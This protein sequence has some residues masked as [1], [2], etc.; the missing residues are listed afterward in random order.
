MSRVLSSD[1]SLNPGLT[2]VILAG[3]WLA[4]VAACEMRRG[5]QRVFHQPLT[6]LERC[7]EPVCPE[8]VCP[9]AAPP[10][11]PEQPEEASPPS[12]APSPRAS[13]PARAAPGPVDLNEASLETLMTL[14]GVG[15][16][17]AE[18]IIAYRQ[19]RPFKSARDLMRV[20]GIG[21]GKYKRLAPKVIVGT[22]K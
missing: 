18:R 9:V 4:A 3:L 21:P 1:R 20:K 22:P 15:R 2:L 12:A 7:P 16:A 17:T 11:E 13:L 19:R 8:P 10:V 14:P 5:E 6:P